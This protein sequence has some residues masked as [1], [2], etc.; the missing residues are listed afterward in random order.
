MNQVDGAVPV[1]AAMPPPATGQVALTLTYMDNSTERFVL[2][3]DAAHTIQCKASIT[4]TGLDLAVLTSATAQCTTYPCFELYLR[5]FNAMGSNLP[6]LPSTYTFQLSSKNTR[7]VISY[8]Y[9]W[10][11]NL[12]TPQSGDDL[13]AL[14][15]IQTT[16]ER[17]YGHCVNDKESQP[18][19]VSFGD[20]RF[21]CDGPPALS[22][23]DEGSITIA[24]SQVQSVSWTAKFTGSPIIAEAKAEVTCPR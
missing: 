9:S 5:R 18:R 12:G 10:M 22:G 15:A 3:N 23:T 17:S 16:K 13:G 4:K 14:F 11:D 6:P 8:M 2:T 19:P 1:D 21:C 20:N 24:G 7:C